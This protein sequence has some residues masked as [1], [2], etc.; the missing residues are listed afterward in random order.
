MK[1][2]TNTGDKSQ[3]AGQIAPAL[4]KMEKTN[5]FTVPDHYFDRLPA[6]ITEKCHTKEQKKVNIFHWFTSVSFRYQLAMASGAILIILAV[7]LVLTIPQNN[8][9]SVA[10]DITWDDVMQEENV[11]YL[12]FDEDVLIEMLAEMNGMEDYST[13]ENVENLTSEDIIDYL[14]NEN[15]ELETLY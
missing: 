7:V 14:M 10:Q 1:K 12:D 8:H 4:S 2:H 6:I 5:P 9:V 11:L 13:D 15:I 3:D